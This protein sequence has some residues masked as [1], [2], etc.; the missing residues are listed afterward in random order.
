MTGD[1][2]VQD[3]VDAPWRSAIYAIVPHPADARILL[4]PSG[5]SYSLPHVEV[6]EEILVNDIGRVTALVRNLFGAD[7][8][9]Y[10]SASFS[11]D[12]RAHCVSGVF[13]VEP[14]P[15]R[16]CAAV[17]GIWADGSALATLPLVPEDHRDV[18]RSYL[19]EVAHDHVP[20]QRPPWARPGW[21][22]EAEAWILAE[23]ASLAY[24]VT[25]PVE[26]VRAW[27]ISCV[28]R[29]HTTAGTIYFKA[30]ANLP[31]CTDEPALL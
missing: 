12:R 9:A 22:R 23:L 14:L 21:F 19:A 29:V 11:V 31:L 2:D 6:V 5:N 7:L 10:R 8:L 27:A 15:T 28:L 26:Q 25:A 24:A 4:F 13:V 18:I 20:D 17:G 1:R 30:A 16:E 3:I